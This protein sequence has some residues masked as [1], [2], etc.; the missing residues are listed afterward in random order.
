MTWSR[1]CCEEAHLITNGD[2]KKKQ[3]QNSNS[4]E[5]NGSSPNIMMSGIAL[6]GTMAYSNK[7][8]VIVFH[9]MG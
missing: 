4:V 3:R 7:N 6:W 9:F 1:K 5:T 2:L 8:A